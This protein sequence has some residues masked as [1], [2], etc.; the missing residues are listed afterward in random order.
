MSFGIRLCTNSSDSRVLDKDLN[1]IDTV[2]GRLRND[3]SVID[4]VVMIEYD[5][6]SLSQLNYI[7]I[8]EFNRSYFVTNI[9]SARNDLIELHCHVDVLRSFRDEIRG[10]SGITSRQKNQFN[11]FLNDGSLKVYQDPIV[12]TQPFPGGFQD[13]DWS[14]VLGVTGG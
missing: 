12:V 1:V 8:P 7:V 9:R 6:A 11:L 2:T 10:C 14:Y 3:T 4:P 13:S 5:L